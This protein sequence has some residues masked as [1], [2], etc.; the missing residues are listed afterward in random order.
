MRE[1]ESSCECSFSNAWTLEIKACYLVASRLL[2]LWRK[3][4]H[5]QCIKTR[6]NLEIIL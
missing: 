2:F 1:L 4:S 3:K 5:F 6:K